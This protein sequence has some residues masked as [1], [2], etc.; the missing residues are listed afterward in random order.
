MS[1]NDRSAENSKPGIGL[2]HDEVT[3]Y[4]RHLIMPE[5]GVAG[6]KKLKEASILIVGAG[7]LGSPMAMYMAACGI[8]RIGLVDYDVVDL[9]NLQRQ[10]IHGTSD[11]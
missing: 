6:Q 1:P 8:G 11:V 7:G 9:S 5:V 10:I 4:S 3:R 2:S